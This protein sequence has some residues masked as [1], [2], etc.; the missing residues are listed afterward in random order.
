MN[1]I[2]LTVLAC[3]SLP[4]KAEPQYAI[5]FYIRSYTLECLK[6]YKFNLTIYYVIDNSNYPKS[7]AG[8]LSFKMVEQMNTLGSREKDVGQ[9]K[10][11]VVD[12]NSILGGSWSLVLSPYFLKGK[13]IANFWISQIGSIE[14][15]VIVERNTFLLQNGLDEFYRTEFMITW[16]YDAR[17]LRYNFTYNYVIIN[18]Y[19]VNRT[20]DIERGFISPNFSEYGGVERFALN[21]SP[22]PT[23]EGYLEDS[24]IENAPIRIVMP[25]LS[26]FNLTLQVEPKRHP[27]FVKEGVFGYNISSLLRIKTPFV[28]KHR[29]PSSF[30]VHDDNFRKWNASI[31][32]NT[33]VFSRNVWEE[34]DIPAMAFYPERPRSVELK[35]SVHLSNVFPRPDD[36][37]IRI[38]ETLVV[39]SI[40]GGNFP[41][42]I[43][44]PLPP[45]SAVISVGDGEREYKKVERG[46]A[47]I[48]MLGGEYKVEHLSNATLV[49]AKVNPRQSLDKLYYRSVVIF[50]TTPNLNYV[51][52]FEFRDGQITF[53]SEDAMLGYFRA[54]ARVIEN[55]RFEFVLPKDADTELSKCSPL[56]ARSTETDGKRTIYWEIHDHTTLQDQYLLPIYVTPIGN[57]VV[58]GW[59][60]LP[61]YVIM[62]LVLFWTFKDAA[63]REKYGR[64]AELASFVGT[65]ATPLGVVITAGSGW[66]LFP[67]I[68]YW[69]VWLSLSP[70]ALFLIVLFCHLAVIPAIRV[71][72]TWVRKAGD[73]KKQERFPKKKTKRRRRK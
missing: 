2:L 73:D 27:I 19:R 36:L 17:Q 25:S 10:S 32:Y 43:E 39:T 72:M 21:V 20:I 67:L 12:G 66:N 59:I 65:L 58:A 9:A 16:R 33:I 24:V 69:K 14:D 37:L 29:V 70:P 38:D 64:K 1:C 61:V 63:R 51:R 35:E 50:R 49:K 53:R 68:S 7:I 11:A 55:A 62:G 6:T 34:A 15:S 52:P 57:I 40:F 22:G 8:M 3:S 30:L 42:I 41:A 56:G 26:S 28:L 18:P 5:R 60:T 48:D 31:S 71:L 45:K 4:S 23:L 44:W 47:D 46:T 54:F 13:A